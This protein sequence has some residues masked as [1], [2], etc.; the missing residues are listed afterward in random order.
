MTGRP[1]TNVPLVL[2]QVFEHRASALEESRAL[3][4]RH[5]GVVDDHRIVREAPDGDAF[6]KGVVLEDDSFILQRKFRHPALVSLIA[7]T[8]R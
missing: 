4:A 8:G 5:R 7:S 2:R 1:L 6:S 3:M